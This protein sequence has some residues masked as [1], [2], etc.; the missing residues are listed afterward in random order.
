VLTE[1][2]IVVVCH[3]SCSRL[4]NILINIY[5]DAHRYLHTHAHIYISTFIYIYIYTC[6]C[7]YSRTHIHT[8]L[9]LYK[10]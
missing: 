3:A 10:T 5:I 4:N 2:V 8:C 1:T 9:H 6:L 7:I